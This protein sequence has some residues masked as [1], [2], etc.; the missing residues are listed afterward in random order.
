MPEAEQLS[1]TISEEHDSIKPHRN[2]QALEMQSGD[3]A[4]IDYRLLHGTEANE[5]ACRRDCVI[6]NFTPHWNHLP[7]DIQAHLASH[8]AQPDEKE[9]PFI[10]SGQSK[11]LPSY[12]G[13][14]VFLNINRLAPPFFKIKF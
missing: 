1:D 13:E 3:A 12:S 8:M 9:Q 5:T 4:V 7:P 10:D 2:Q 14:R 11:I 6:L